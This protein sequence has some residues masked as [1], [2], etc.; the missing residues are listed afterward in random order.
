MQKQALATIA[1]HNLLAHGDGIVVGL[2]G[3]ADSVA[4]THFLCNLTELDLKI[5]CVH[6]HHGLRGD[7]ADRD[8]RFCEEF[9]KQLGVEL[10]TIQIDAAKEARK[11]GITVEESG[12]FFRYNHFYEERFRRGFGKIAVAH[13]RNDVVETIIMQIARGSGGIRG[14]PAI[15]RHVIRPLIDASRDDIIAYCDEHK[16]AYCSDSTNNS[17]DYTRNWVRNFLI[18]QIKDN[19]NP[20]LDDALLRLA[21]ISAA[22]NKYLDDITKNANET[23]LITED[24]LVLINLEALARHDLAIRRRIIRNV[25]AEMLCDMKDITFDHVESVLALANAQSGKRVSLPKGYVAEKQYHHICIKV[26]ADIEEFSVILHENTPIFV[27]QIGSWVC[28]CDVPQVENAFTKVLDCGKI[29]GCVVQVRTR[30][31]GDRIFFNTVGTKKIKDFF[32]DKKM[33]R[34][35]RE[36]AVF[37]A[38]ERD[39]IL[40]MG[41]GTEKPIESHKFNPENDS[42]TIYLQIWND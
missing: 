6:V 31:A 24:D 8:A 30:L 33:S 21:K 40:I 35:M 15:N 37:I 34:E 25:I 23:W 14:I 27:P 1:E 3:G 41:V 16:L 20:S 26:L 29:T 36:K 28:I 7:E 39:I 5:I 12:R 4:L 13:N 32:I 19:L 17:N 11:M 9:C 10:V 22:E 42:K 2:S 38:C 18:P